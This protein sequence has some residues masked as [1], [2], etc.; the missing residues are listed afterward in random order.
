VKFFG[1]ILLTYTLTTT[2]QDTKAQTLTTLPSS[3]QATYIDKSTSVKP[4]FSPISSKIKLK[5][6]GDRLDVKQ[7]IEDTTKN[8]VGRDSF[9]KMK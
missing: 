4:I 1:S 2:I 8:L 3:D 7:Q 5:S 6:G 9:D